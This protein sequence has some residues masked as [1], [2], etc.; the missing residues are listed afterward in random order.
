MRWVYAVFILGGC[1]AAY[2]IFCLVGFILVQ[3]VN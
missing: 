1:V 3:F 2:L